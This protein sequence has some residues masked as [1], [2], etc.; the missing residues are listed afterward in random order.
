MGISI[1]SIKIKPKPDFGRFLKALKRTGVPDRVPFYEIFS[2][3]QPQVMADVLKKG[4]FK[5]EKAYLTRVNVDYQHR[6]GYDFVMEQAPVGFLVPASHAGETTEG[7][8]NYVQAADSLIR[9]MEDFEKYA[10]PDFSKADF[11]QLERT[12]KILPEGMKI[13]P[14]G[15]GGVLENVMWIMGY[16]PMSYAFV[17]DEKLIAA[18]FNAVGSRIV[19]LAEVYAGLDF[20]GGM[21]IGDDMGFKTQTLISPEMMRQ[22]VMPWHKKI[23]DV[24]HAKNKPIILH[25]CGQLERIYDD[26]IG[27]GWEGKHSFE[28][29]IMPVWDFKVRYGK[30]ITALGGFD[31]VKICRLSPDEIRKHTRFILD[32]CA[33]KGGYLFGTGNSVANYVPVEN[34]LT[35]IEE[36]Y[37]YGK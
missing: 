28:D 10:W 9:N 21:T 6:L 29:N 5:D 17:E 16:E 3:I 15:P 8:R 36:A 37:N 22:Y 4:D 13:M 19:K 2:N 1:Q 30:R 32:K 24:F 25:S 18:M 26:I 20:V 33:P 31:M 7:K 23:V 14:L 11:S 35:A 34:F 27:C 12:A